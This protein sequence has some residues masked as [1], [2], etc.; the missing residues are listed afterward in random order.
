MSLVVALVRPRKVLLKACVHYRS[1]QLISDVTPPSCNKFC[2]YSTFPHSLELDQPILFSRYSKSLV[3]PMITVALC[4]S[5]ALLQQSHSF[6]KFPCDKMA[7]LYWSKS[8][9]SKSMQPS[10]PPIGRR[11]SFSTSQVDLTHSDDYVVTIVNII[12]FI[13]TSMQ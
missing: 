10:I 3:T 13:F 7:A 11:L 2:Y 5:M 1:Y 6:P 4:T 12:N 9:L 8:S